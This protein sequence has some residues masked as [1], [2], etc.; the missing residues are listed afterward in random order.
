M[1]EW[2]II[3]YLEMLIPLT[4][5][6]WDIP[7]NF[8]EKGGWLNR[9]TS[10]YFLDYANIMS[11]K[12]GDRVKNWI[13]HNEPWVIA[14]LGFTE[15]THAPGHKSLFE[16]LKVSHHLL[17]SHG[18]AV[19]IIR[20]N[21]KDSKVGITLNLTP[22]YPASP[23]K[24]DTKAAN[25][26]D[27]FFNTW[28][29]NPLYGKNYPDEIIQSWKDEGKLES[30]LDFIKRK[31]LGIISV[32]TDFLGINYYSRAINRCTST[33]EEEICLLKLFLE[34]KQNLNGRF[35]QMD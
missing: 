27:Q 5:N 23:S 7:Q 35:F 33:S 19:P 20:S 4:L 22:A 32:K 15:G 29:L 3:C 6:H 11:E 21:S 1:K 30:D 28:Y 13:T 16:T 34:R 31:D 9:D 10:K 2:L 26:F 18:Q 8:Y 12:L 25:L 24:V 14:Y 17:L